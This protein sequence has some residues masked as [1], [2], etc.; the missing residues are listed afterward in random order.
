[1][2]AVSFS[3][4]TDALRRIALWI[5]VVFPLAATIGMRSTLYDGIRHLQF[6]YPVLVVL[7]VSGWTGILLSSRPSWL[8]AGAATCLAVGLA[9]VLTFDIRFHPNQ[10][11]YFNAVIGGPRRAFAHYDMDY[12]GN[13]VLQA[14]E[15]S[16]DAAR[17]SGTPI[18]ISGQPDHLVQLNAE[19]FREV[20]FTYPSRNRH[21]LQIQLA[22]GPALALRKLARQPALHQ[23]RTADGAVLCTVMPGP[24][25][26]ELEPLRRYLAAREQNHQASP[27]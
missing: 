26:G 2:S 1:L 27:Q 18:A 14:V 24:A 10:G 23:V 12:W 5:L 11:V 20:Y 3:S 13:C 6:I 21:H 8:R 19:R 9:S 25:L 17:S 4:R 15:W 22:R 16:V 7:A